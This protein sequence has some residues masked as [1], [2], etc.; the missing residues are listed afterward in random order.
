MTL[1]KL[2]I[3][4][5]QG[6]RAGEFIK[7]GSVIGVYTGC[8]RKVDK[9]EVPGTYLLLGWWDSGMDDYVTTPY[10]VDSEFEGNVSPRLIPAI[11]SN[12]LSAGHSLRG[13]HYSTHLCWVH[14][15]A[16]LLVRTPCAGPT[17]PSYFMRMVDV[18]DQES[19]CGYRVQNCVLVAIFL[20]ASS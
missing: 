13:T 5:H 11:H 19:A 7:K 14:Q 4:M 9:G 12:G 15:D 16:N 6:V 2:I 8:I 1:A 3:R 10:A 20:P 17:P 18:L